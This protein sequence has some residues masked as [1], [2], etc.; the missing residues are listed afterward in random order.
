MFTRVGRGSMYSVGSVPDPGDRGG[1]YEVALIRSHQ[2]QQH[3]RVYLT[4]Y[5]GRGREVGLNS[6]GLDV[7]TAKTVAE[8]L[9][10]AGKIAEGD[11]WERRAEGRHQKCEVQ[12]FAT[13]ELGRDPEPWRGT[14][15]E[16]PGGPL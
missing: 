3:D 2:G 6:V 9:L 8:L 7:D 16:A 4:R 1:H 5:S 14:V 12:R 10:S 13:S 15:G 11:H